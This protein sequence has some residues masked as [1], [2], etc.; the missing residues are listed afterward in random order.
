MKVVDILPLK[1]GAVLYP[2]HEKIKSLM[3]DEISSHGRDY[4]HKKVDAYEKGL[5]HFDY[6]SPL[7]N[8]KYKDFREWIELQ[9]EIYARD[10]L[11]FDTSEYVLTDSWM[12]VCNSGGRQKHHY[13]INAVVCALYYVNFD[14]EVHA[15]TY[16]YRP[17]NSMNYPDYFAYMLTNQKETKY[18]YINEVVGVEGSLLLWTANTCHGYKTNYTDNRITIS[19]NL[20]PRYINDFR[21]EPLT[22]DERHTAMT[23]MRSGKLW[24]YPLF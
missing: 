15:P 22:K 2:E 14:D 17:N 1:L 7:S 24:D 12:N 6:Y 10:I 8:D 9:A 13:H 20:M 23:E 11:H 5:E 19:S 16:F 18:N 4:E 21:V 3:L